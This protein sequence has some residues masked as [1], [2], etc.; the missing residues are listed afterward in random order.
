MPTGLVWDTTSVAWMNNVVLFLL[1]VVL[2]P[3]VEEF[4]FRGI[5]L[6]RLA[7]RSGRAWGIFWT[8]LLF[9]VFHADL[10]GSLLFSVVLCIL[11]LRTGTLWGAVLAHAANN[12][13]A[14]V[15]MVLEGPEATS[16]E[17]F[18]SQWW[19]GVVG[20]LVAVPWLNWF[21][22]RRVPPVENCGQ[23]ETSS[24]T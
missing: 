9:G 3:L 13:L 1:I 19:L 22:R 5:V 14:F 7:A 8:S 24:S 15:G 16:L 11:V 4:L 23:V 6:H 20:L 2:A 17:Q 12:L 10:L 18:Q 21:L